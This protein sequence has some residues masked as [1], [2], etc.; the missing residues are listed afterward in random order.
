MAKHK[1]PLPKGVHRVR[2][3]LASGASKFHFYAWRG[4]PK[5]W[6]SSSY[7]PCQEPGFN[8][9]FAAEIAAPKNSVAYKYSETVDWLVD[10]YL[11]SAAYLHTIGKRSQKD[12]KL[13]LEKFRKE[14]GCEPYKILEEWEFSGEVQE[15]RQAW[16]HSP[17]Q[18]DY[19]GA[20]V[21]ILLNWACKDR[22]LIKEHYCKEFPKIYKS[23]RS[24][25]ILS[26]SDLERLYGE[27]PDWGKRM[28]TVA[29]ETGLRPSDLVKLNRR[30]LKGEEGVRLL[31]VRTA[32]RNK[33]AYIPV[34]KTLE[35]HIQEMPE[36]QQYFVVGGSGIPISARWASQKFREWRNKSKL[37]LAEDGRE[38]T[39]SDTRGTAATRLLDA[40]LSLKEIANFMGWSIRYAAN[41][42]E[43][44]A[45]IS[46]S[47]SAAILAK[48]EKA[49]KDEKCKP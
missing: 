25:I 43:H 40:N 46:P 22:R 2:R 35:K 7:C 17:K 5:F 34:S 27:A 28:I 10:Q 4:G 13:W 14:F 42:I 45:K 11:G 26:P 3:K 47:E 36:G 29:C 21:S 15:W 19:A 32:K 39:L 16:V 48:L 44:Y 30:H 49:K 18:Y 6:E 12:Y 9:A 33:V 41:V 20:I 24:E 31:E 37:P 8:E 23:N 1:C 38:K